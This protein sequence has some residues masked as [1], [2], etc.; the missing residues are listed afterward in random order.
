MAD[1]AIIIELKL[2]L[3][4]YREKPLE[5]SQARSLNNGKILRPRGYIT[6]QTKCLCLQLNIITRRMWDYCKMLSVFY[7]AIFYLVI[8][9]TRIP[10]NFLYSF[11]SET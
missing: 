10:F 11:F 8:C 9:G 6:Y 1:V 5:I 4:E 3:S 2:I 7:L